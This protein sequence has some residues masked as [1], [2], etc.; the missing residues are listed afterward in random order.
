MSFE[1]VPGI[2]NVADFLNKLSY[3]CK[4]N[5]ASADEFLLHKKLKHT[6]ELLSIDPFYP[7]LNSHEI[8]ELTIRY[9]KKVFTSYVENNKPNAKRI[10]WVYGPNQGQITII[11]IEPHPN[12]KANSYKKIKLSHEP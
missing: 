1:I 7:G 10:Y 3:K 9:G 2:P 12:D 5:E 6:F 11:S 8:G 4:N